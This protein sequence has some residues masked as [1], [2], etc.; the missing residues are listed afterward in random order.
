M[1]HTCNPL[2]AGTKYTP[3]VSLTEFAASDVSEI[4]SIIPAAI[5]DKNQLIIIMYRI[6]SRKMKYYFLH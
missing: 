6:S 3:S 1:K 2:N 5:V 4:L